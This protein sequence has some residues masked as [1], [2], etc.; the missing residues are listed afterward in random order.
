MILGGRV[1]LFSVR[2][3]SGQTEPGPEIIYYRVS[4]APL[5][6]A[7]RSFPKNQDQLRGAVQE[8]QATSEIHQPLIYSDGRAVVVTQPHE[9]ESSGAED[10]AHAP[11][12]E[13]SG[14]QQV[15]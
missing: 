10:A 8:L 15:F 12:S 9:S 13:T 6:S 14:L 3:R 1:K 7:E 2:W 11:A 5:S 4:A